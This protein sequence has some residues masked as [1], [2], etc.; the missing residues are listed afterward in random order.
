MQDSKGQRKSARIPRR[1]TKPLLVDPI[2]SDDEAY[3]DSESDFEA[4]ESDE[5]DEIDVDEDEATESDEDDETDVDEDDETD[6]DKDDEIEVEPVGPKDATVDENGWI[7]VGRQPIKAHSPD[8]RSAPRN[9]ASQMVAQKLVM[10]HR[11]VDRHF[12]GFTTESLKEMRDTAIQQ[13][14]GSFSSHRADSV[15]RFCDYTGL[16]ISWTPG[17]R[18]MSLEGVYRFVVFN[19]QLGYHASPNLA[20]IMTSINYAKKANPPVVLPLLAVWLNGHNEPDFETRKATWAW[21]FNALSNAS[22]MHQVLYTRRHK[23]QIIEVAKWTPEKQ[24]AVLQVWRT[25]TRCAFVDDT[26]S[27]EN[28]A[29]RLRPLGVMLKYSGKISSTRT[30]SAKPLN[31]PQKVYNQLLRIGAKYGLSRQEFEYYCTIPSPRG[32]THRVFYPYHILSRP[33]A[34]AS[35]WDWDTLMTAAKHF[36]FTMRTQ[37][38]K[39]A[40]MAGHGESQVDETLFIYWMATHFSDKIQKLKIDRP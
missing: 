9:V 14:Q 4:T 26:L 32:K 22:I 15:K 8:V 27:D 10:N 35:G 28:C 25:G 30:Q 23:Q 19:G 13:L 39:H 16:E 24:K 5:D 3:V 37:C 11:E 20:M 1:V 34:E 17:P 33:Q 6:V 18:S 29:N 12:P 40:E 21:A 31:S 36:L 2:N 38:N 7:R